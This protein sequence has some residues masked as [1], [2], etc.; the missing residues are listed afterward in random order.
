MGFALGLRGDKAEIPGREFPDK[1][2]THSLSFLRRVDNVRF[3]QCP[4]PRQFR[5]PT[6]LDL[7]RG[8]S[9][10]ADKKSGWIDFFTRKIVRVRHTADM[11]RSSLK[12][13]NGWQLTMFTCSISD[14]TTVGSLTSLELI[15]AI[16]NQPMSNYS[17]PISIMAIGMCFCLTRAAAD[18]LESGVDLTARI[19]LKNRSEPPQPSNAY[20]GPTLKLSG[21]K[22]D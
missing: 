2:G 4:V 22:F 19:G 17:K 6:P 5:H 14:I 9:I 8:K 21:Q 11:N 10:P 20:E 13:T 7:F 12:S 1:V 15:G 16:P 3:F 18:T